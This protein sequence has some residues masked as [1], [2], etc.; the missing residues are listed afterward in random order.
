V[1][2]KVKLTNL[3]ALASVSA[4][5]GQAQPAQLEITVRDQVFYF[6]TGDLS[7]FATSQDMMMVP[8][9]PPFQ[10]CVGIA[11]VIAVNGRPVKGALL[12]HGSQLL[13]SPN[14]TPGR[15]ISDIQRAALWSVY[16]EILETDGRQIGTLMASGMHG[17]ATDSLPGGPRAPAAAGNWAI[18]GGTGAFVGVS[19]Q[20]VISGNVQ[21]QTVRIVS[22]ET[23]PLTRRLS[24]MGPVK[25]VVQLTRATQPEVARIPTGPAV[26]HPDFSPVTATSPAAPGEALIVRATGLGP[27]RGSLESGQPFPADPLAIVNS[28]V[29]VHVAGVSAEVINQVGWP[30]TLDQYRIDF[31][32]PASIG[33]G[34]VPMRLSAA[35]IPG[36]EV[37]IPVR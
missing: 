1:K 15:S 24:G 35:W 30:G 25:Y 13:P 22:M 14:P 34:V 10:P 4:L 6:D 26:F 9:F 36:P 2:V 31:R 7:R 11:D 18:T 29:E 17:G 33:A 28:P 3:V 12:M 16:L 37:N 20:M 23:D 5:F 27:V 19:G 32:L 8:R 21:N